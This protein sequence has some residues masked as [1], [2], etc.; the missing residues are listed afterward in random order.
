MKSQ[1]SCGRS[2]GLDGSACST[3]TDSVGACTL[4]PIS[5]ATSWA[6]LAEWQPSRTTEAGRPSSAACFSAWTLGL[7]LRKAPISAPLTTTCAGSGP[8]APGSGA[9]SSAKPRSLACPAKK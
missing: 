9:T 5:S 7:R 3:P 6:R 4:R 2:Y 8:A 1:A